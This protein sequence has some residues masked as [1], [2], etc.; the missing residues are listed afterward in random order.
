[1]KPYPRFMIAA[2]HKSSG[3]TVISTGLAAAL[4]RSGDKVSTF[5]KG[6]DYIDPMWLS[7][8]S[9]GACYN[10][11]FNAMDRGEISR[12][13]T[14]RASELSL[15]EANKGLFDGVAVDG[16][17]SNAELAKLLGLPVILV[18]DTNGMTRG[19]APLLQGYQGFDPDVNIAGVILNKVGGARHEAK[20]RRAVE[21]YSDLPVLGSV[22]RHDKLEIGERHLGLTTPA[23]LTGRDGIIEGFAD[24]VAGSVDLEVLRA[25]AATAPDLQV[26]DARLDHSQV[27]NGLRIGVIRDTAF[28]FYYWDDLEAFQAAGAELV[29]ID[30]IRDA[31]LPEIDGLLIGGG[32]PEMRMKELAANTS[33]RSDIKQKLTN[34]L[35]CYAE[36]GGLMYL[37]DSLH[38]NGQVAAMVGLIPGDAVMHARPQGR[39]YARFQ[40]TA[41]HPWWEGGRLVKAHEFHYASIN[42]LSDTVAFAR[43]IQ[44]GHGFDGKRDGVVIS[45][46]LAGF[47]HLHNSDSCPWVAR[48]LGFVA[49]NTRLPND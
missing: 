27:G 18:I 7:A 24:V 20:L 48:F 41:N 26:A 31:H 49:Q 10:L 43:D 34:G 5:K 15:V 14:T 45:N 22:W 6:P 1:M 25:M 21:I 29:F 13:F 46:T 4:R 44:R 42:N 2:A 32:F 11:D 28:G 9:G 8:A 30:A 47:C 19:I 16:S 37:C 40:A 3:K 23:E 36:C 33:L 12:L 39:G 17:D 38:W 35:P